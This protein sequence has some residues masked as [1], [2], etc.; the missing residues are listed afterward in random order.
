M[1]QARGKIIAEILDTATFLIYIGTES[2]SMKHDVDIA[3]DTS[4]DDTDR[5]IAFF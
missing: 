2:Y 3:L 5:C 4:L 1:D